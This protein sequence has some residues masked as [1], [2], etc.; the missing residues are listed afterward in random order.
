MRAVSV[1]S[2]AGNIASRMPSH[3]LRKVHV[4]NALE[5][6]AANIL[7]CLICVIFFLHPFHADPHAAVL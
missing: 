4:L 2:Y 5:L 1:V 3:R 7:L 6:L